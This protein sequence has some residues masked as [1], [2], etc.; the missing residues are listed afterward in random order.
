VDLLIEPLAALRDNYIW[1]LSRGGRAAVVDPGV[2]APVLAALSRQGLTLTAILVTHHHADHVGGI[3]TLKEHYDVPVYGPANELIAAIEHPLAEGASIQ[4]LDTPWQVL[5]IPGHT[6]GHIAF[7]AAAL[8]PPVLFC[9]DTLFGCG[10]GR[11]FEGTAAQ[12]LAA[13]DR[14]AGLPPATRVYCAHEYTLANIRFAQQVEP[15]NA[16][17]LERAARVE[18]QRAAGQCSLPSTI[19]EERHTNPFLR[20]DDPGVQAQVA[21]QRSTTHAA[22][23]DTFA[24]LRRWKD[25][26]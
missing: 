23:L 6:A 14:L 22:R 4:V 15:S 26:F 16:A 8:N 10:C 20:I 19:E 17:L 12:L 21:R 25:E 9:G 18:R 11:I 13:L 3:A 7:Y 24:A 1:L 2:A 5:D